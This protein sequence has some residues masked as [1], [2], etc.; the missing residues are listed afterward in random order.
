MACPVALF[1]TFWSREVYTTPTVLRDEARDDYDCKRLETVK[2]DA[3]A[4]DYQAR[5][6]A[7]SIIL[8]KDPSKHRDNRFRRLTERQLFSGLNNTDC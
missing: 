7:R 8:L 1:A 6:A 2:R 3:L 5:R 4:K